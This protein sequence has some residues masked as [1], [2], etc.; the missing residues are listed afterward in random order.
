VDNMKKRKYYVYIFRHG[1][2]YFNKQHIFTGWLDSTLTPLG[3]QQARIVA[4]K[5]RYKTIGIAIQTRLSRSR[6]SLKEVLKYHPECQR[7]ITDDRI[8]ERNYGTLNGVPHK[9]FIQRIGTREYDLLK[10]GDAIE[11][12]SASDRKKVERL[13]GEEEFRAIHRGYSVRPP[14]GESFQDVEKRVKSFIKDLK[15]LIK[16]EKT[17]IVISAHGNSIRLFRKIMEKKTRDEAVKWFIPYTK[18]FVYSF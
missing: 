15:K 11:N 2:T 5:L 17:N 9:E 14:G 10:E 3:K 16:K 4:K 12:L 6:E 13:L 18:V 7:I 8:I 1:Q